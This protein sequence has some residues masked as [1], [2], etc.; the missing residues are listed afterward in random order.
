MKRLYL[1][2]ILIFALL[3]LASCS[4]ADVSD[5]IRSSAPSVSSQISNSQLDADTLSRINQGNDKFKIE[6]RSDNKTATRIT[7]KISENLIRN[8][9]DALEAI[10][11]VKTL[12]GIKDPEK[13]LEFLKRYSAEGLTSYRFIQL[14]KGLQVYP[15]LVTLTVS[16]STHESTMLYSDF[17]SESYFDDFSTEPKISLKSIQYDYMGVADPD[18]IFLRIYI[19]NSDDKLHP[20]LCYIV[21]KENIRLI[22]NA[23]TRDIIKQLKVYE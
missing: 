14:Y 8:Q 18:K 21:E 1:I 15:H 5:N 23:N 20:V 4:E 6:Y 22:I 3:S 16:D 7:G 12:L 19:E 11:G 17:I 10:K 13:D 9:Q 2:A